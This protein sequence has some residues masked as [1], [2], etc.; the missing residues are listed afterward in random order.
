MQQQFEHYFRDQETGLM[1]SFLD[2]RTMLPPLDAFFNGFSEDP[3][4]VVD[5]F[6]L[7][8]MFM[9][10]NFGI[11]TGSYMSAEALRYE[12]TGAEDA[13]ESMHRSLQGF[14]LVY[15]HGKQLAHGFYPKFYGRRFSPETSTDQMLYSILGMEAYYPFADA[16]DKRLIEDMIPALV[17]F[18]VDRDYRYH[19]FHICDENW[20]WPLVR[21]PS[22][23]KIAEHFSGDKLFRNEYQKLMI[24]TAKPEH[25]ML[26]DRM[27]EKNPSDYEKANHAW[28]TVNGADRIGMDVTQFDLLLRYD[29]ENPLAGFWK[30]GIRWMWEEVKDSLTEDGR[31]YSMTLFDFDTLKCRQTPGWS[32]DRSAYSGAKSSWSTFVVRSGLIALRHVPEIAGEVIT[33]AE[34]VLEKLDFNDCTYYDEPEHFAPEERF[35]PKLLSG[36]AIANWL[37]T[38]GLLKK[39]KKECCEKTKINATD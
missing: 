38:D 24:H 6:S 28:L 27:R 11:S 13:L 4:L 39:Y 33:A 12:L 5:G 8:E 15:E 1:F 16:A 30:G 7:A 29:S 37:W 18:W 26:L 2:R 23:L 36:D 32:V 20:Q 21:F 3:K 19:F 34:R 17:K 10:E 14:V 31:Y 9:H 35:K 22:L 25:C